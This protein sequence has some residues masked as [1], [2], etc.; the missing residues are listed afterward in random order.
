MQHLEEVSDQHTESDSSLISYGSREL[1]VPRTAQNRI[2]GEMVDNSLALAKESA[3]AHVDL[4]ALVIQGSRLQRAG[5]GITEQNTQAFELFYR[6]ALGEHNEARFRLG[7]CYLYG[8][9]IHTNSVEGLKWLKQSA[10]AGFQ[11]AL[12]RL[13]LLYKQ[14]GVGVPKDSDESIRWFQKAAQAGNTAACCILADIFKD[15]GNWDEEMN[16]YKEAALQGDKDFFWTVGRAY[17]DAREGTNDLPEA[18]AWLQLLAD[19][20][21]A[22]EHRERASA[23]KGCMSDSE[24]ANGIGLYRYYEG[25]IAKWLSKK[26]AKDTKDANSFRSAAEAGDAMAQCSLGQRY[27]NG[28]GVPKDHTEAVNWFRKAAEQGNATAQLFLAESYN[29]GHGVAQNHEVAVVWFRRAARG[30]HVHAQL[31]LGMCYRDGLG[32]TQDD[33]EAVIWYRAAAEN[34][35]AFAQSVLAKCYTTGIGV[36]L[37]LPQAHAWLRLAGNTSAETRALEL[38]MSPSDR[39]KANT[40]YEDLKERHTGKQ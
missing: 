30:G 27:Q 33:A 9:G 5:E 8:D 39:G 2:L 26:L 32:V 34:G 19:A 29:S 18:Y 14:G 22:S 25:E 11:P 16:W 31:R 7:C 3:V 24:L 35:Y 21:S 12:I 4:D 15:R 1:I 37:D 38:S 36:E 13:G 10:T 28:R 6:A 20:S 40:L 23:L 17:A